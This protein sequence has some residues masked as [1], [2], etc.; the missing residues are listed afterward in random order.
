MAFQTKYDGLNDLHT[1]M[2][3]GAAITALLAIDLTLGAPTAVQLNAAKLE[4]DALR[5]NAAYEGVQC[6]AMSNSILW[7][8]IASEAGGGSETSTTEERYEAAYALINKINALED[9]N[10]A[11]QAAGDISTLIAIDYTAAT[12]TASQLKAAADAWEAIRGN[13][14]YGY[15]NLTLPT[16]RVRAALWSEIDTDAAA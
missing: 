1:A 11:I 2:Q 6:P 5:N 9:L 13:T 7:N 15:G 4:Y 16:V 8:L 12:P 3:A 10:T 14:Q